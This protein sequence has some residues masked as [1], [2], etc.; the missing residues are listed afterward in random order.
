[1]SSTEKFRQEFYEELQKAL[2][3]FKDAEQ[4]R[5]RIQEVAAWL[6]DTSHITVQ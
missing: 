4:K 3:E 5:S 6:F 1:M 2:R